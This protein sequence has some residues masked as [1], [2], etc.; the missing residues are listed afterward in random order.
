MIESDYGCL[1][2]IFKKDNLTMSCDEYSTPLGNKIIL[3]IDE[4]EVHFEFAKNGEL[5]S[6]EVM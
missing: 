1:K 6:V 3:F 4:D 5:T 2:R